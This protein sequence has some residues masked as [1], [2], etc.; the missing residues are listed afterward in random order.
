LPVIRYDPGCLGSQCYN[1]LAAEVI[2]SNMEG[3]Q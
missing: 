1:E 2:E 3:A